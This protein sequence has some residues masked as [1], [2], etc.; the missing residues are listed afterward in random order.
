MRRRGL[1]YEENRGCFIGGCLAV[2]I[3][4]VPNQCRERA[5]GVPDDREYDHNDGECYDH[6]G[7]GNANKHECVGNDFVGN[8]NEH[9]RIHIPKN[10]DVTY[11]VFV[12]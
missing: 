12:K 6:I 3:D 10:F 1:L 8:K 7:F 9:F 4:G 11:D 5:V 2:N